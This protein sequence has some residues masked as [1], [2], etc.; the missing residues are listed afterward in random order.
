METIESIFMISVI[1]GSVLFWASLIG[2][3]FD[4]NNKHINA[5]KKKADNKSA[6]YTYG[7]E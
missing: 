1:V 3:M 6:K 2:D 5:H 4:P 7:E